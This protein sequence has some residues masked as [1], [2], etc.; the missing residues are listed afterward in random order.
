M[1]EMADNIAHDLK[2][3]ITRIRGTAENALMRGGPLAGCDPAAGSIVEECD[4]MLAMI[5]AMLDISEAEAGVAEFQT[6]VIDFSETVQDACD[7]FHPVAEDNG[8][9]MVVEAGGVAFVRGDRMKIQ[10]AIA[11]ILDN[12]LKYTPA[13]GAI[14]VSVASDA[15]HI[16]LAISD[17]GP[18]ISQHDMTRIFDRFYRGDKSRSRPGAGLGLPLARAIARA[19]GGDV[20][21]TSIPGQG[22]TFTLILPPFFPPHQSDAIPS[23]K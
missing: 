10:R 16:A 22:S 3:P 4:R 6:E 14:T 13:G 18:G 1:R 9:R 21:V 2:S 8:L 23:P 19:H 20:T 11:N 17:T 12:A 5:N 15:S 7:L